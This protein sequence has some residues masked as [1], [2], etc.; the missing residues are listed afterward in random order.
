MHE[1][2]FFADE[3]AAGFGLACCCADCSLED[4]DAEAGGTW[5]GGYV[6]GEGDG[7]VFE[8]AEVDHGG[9][10]ESSRGLFVI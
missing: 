9:S 1:H 7:V 5:G 10:T 2:F 3:F 4:A 8:V 6:E